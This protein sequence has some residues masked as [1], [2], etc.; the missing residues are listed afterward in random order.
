ML[1]LSRRGHLRQLIHAC[2][3]TSLAI[4]VLGFA[5]DDGD[6]EEVVVTGSYIRN[7]AFAQ[8]SNVNTV[9]ATDLFESGAPSMANYIRDLT[10]TQNTDVVANV[11]SSQD[12]A[13]DAVGA[14]FNLR[15]LGEN[16]TLTLVNGVRVI[17]PSIVNALPDIAIDRMEVVLDGGSALYGSDA[18]A[19]VVNIIPL[20]EF[21][22]FRARTQ[23]QRDQE[24]TFEESSASMV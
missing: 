21:D 4:P 2:L 7:S 18:V 16:S 24:D 5:Q 23:W 15:G 13:Q 11:L 10:Y 22:G 20:R 3:T 9:T 6:I 14:S 12:G 17:D 1:N 19:G 8:D